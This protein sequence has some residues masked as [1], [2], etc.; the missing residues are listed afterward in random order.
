MYE[1][2]KNLL[3]S[4][5]CLTLLLFPTFPPGSA[6]SAEKPDFKPEFDFG[7]MGINGH[8][9]DAATGEEIP[10]DK[11][12]FWAYPNTAESAADVEKIKVEAPGYLPTY[13]RNFS[14]RA[15]NL[16]FLEL[17][18]VNIG[19]V[20]LSSASSRQ[21][22]KLTVKSDP[23]GGAIYIDGTYRG[24]TPERR[25]EV[26]AGSH[27]IRIS[28]K[29]YNSWSADF[30]IN[31]GEHK[32]ITAEE[33]KLKRKNKPPDADFIY[34]PY[35]PPTG[36]AVQFASRSSDPDGRLVSC[37][38]KFGD[39]NRNWGEQ[40]THKYEERG[41]YSVTLVVTDEDDATDSVTKEI[42][43]RQP[44]KPPNADFTYSP[45]EISPGDVVHFNSQASDPD[46]YISSWN[47]QFGDGSES[48]NRNPD[49]QYGEAGTYQVVLKVKDQA[50]ATDVTKKEI[51]VKSSE[52][53]ASFRVTPENPAAGEKVKLDASGSSDP[54]GDLRSYRWDLDG[55]GEVDTKTE[56][57]KLKYEFGEPGRITVTLTVIDGE[58][59]RGSVE[60]V[61]SIKKRPEAVSVD[62]KYALVVG[63]SEYKYEEEY[64]ALELKY[65]AKD[66]KAFY[67]L[68]VDDEA[69][70]FSENRVT[71]LLNEEAKKD[72]IDA[73][74]ANLV[75]EAESD[76]L[77]VIYYSGHG[78]QGPDYDGDEPDSSDEYY[79]TYDTD[80]AT[81]ESIFKTA[82]R[83]DN[84]A[85][86]IRSM[87]SDQVAIFLD[88]CYSGGATKS[89]KGFSLKGY[90]SPSPGSV[91]TDFRFE[92]AEGSVLFAASKEN[93]TSYE[94]E[95]EEIK[96]GLF[97][98]FLLK[99]LRGEA[100]G[101][102]DG[103]ITVAELK[104]YIIPRVSDYVDEHN[105][106]ERT[107]GGTPQTPLVKGGIA[108]P[109]MEKSSTL[110]GMVKY[111]IGG[112]E[113]K[114]GESVMIDLGS[115]DGVQ[116]GDKFQ[117]R[118]SLK[119]VDLAKKPKTVLEVEKVE[120][121]HISKCIVLRAE[122]PVEKGF[123]VRFIHK[124]SS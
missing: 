54:D 109:L 74:L 112:A 24:R 3:L 49:H 83:D 71:L 70:G 23:P 39:G 119:G 69:G 105:L 41:N 38:W 95:G 98:H 58:G 87:V 5:F 79:V 10:K 47:W 121:P 6:L 25:L 18:V 104:E 12:S 19:R 68:L 53:S 1:L 35:N 17:V 14:R 50:G 26:E 30:Y 63:I 116:K 122:K 43:V 97:T 94:G 75:T 21:L 16:G 64:P 80:P 72:R 103:T 60:K 13:V 2:K 120:G 117:A 48:S 40:V 55:D 115:E 86:R 99:G 108:A 77:V 123:K 88:S 27:E 85:D 118:L 113:A 65:A 66:A 52:P 4:V 82:Y 93:Q 110:E 57:P 9:Y 91:F 61:I 92:E 44:N 124:P 32:T 11:I 28:K 46:G 45:P 62:E 101:N 15:V 100:D 20:E 84:F 96:H 67:N 7:S 114:K 56:G 33:A 31:S 8:I 29:E 37:R 107:S 106:P 78:V 90:K 89:V 42:K 34:S 73:A 51:E 81:S 76:D 111:V 36:E 22:P 102:M 59:S